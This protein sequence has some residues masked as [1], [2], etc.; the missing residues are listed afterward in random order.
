MRI[1]NDAR[2]DLRKKL[3]RDAVVGP[4]LWK[5]VGCSGFGLIEVVT[6]PMV[7]VLMY[8]KGSPLTAVKTLQMASIN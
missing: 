3:W 7:K 5:V 4:L 2:L 1:M 8:L 6:A